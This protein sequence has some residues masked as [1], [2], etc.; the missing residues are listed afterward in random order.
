MQKSENLA[1]KHVLISNL[2]KPAEINIYFGLEVNQS[3]RIRPRGPPREIVL[4]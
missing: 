2:V 3:S 1:Q 4:F